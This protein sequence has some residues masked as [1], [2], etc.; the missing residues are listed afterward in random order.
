MIRF[1]I[2]PI[3]WLLVAVFLLQ[4]ATAVE[5]AN[6]NDTLEMEL[7]S[8]I[9]VIKLNHGLKF[10]AHSEF[11]LPT[12]VTDLLTDST[13]NPEGVR[14]EIRHFIT[15][16]NKKKLDPPGAPLTH[17]V[18]R[19]NENDSSSSSG[20]SEEE[21]HN[22][23]NKKEKGNHKKGK[24]DDK[25]SKGDD[26]ESKGDDKESKGDDKKSKGD[27]KK[28]GSISKNHTSSTAD[29]STETAPEQSESFR[30]ARPNGGVSRNGLETIQ[31]ESRNK[32]TVRDV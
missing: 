26:K 11:D 12:N 25:E 31:E 14:I 21:N 24:G 18:R 4:H 32:T 19:S 30:R 17:R 5:V 9:T 16:R 2:L 27:D 1:S 15:L 3:S 28:E 7:D 13:G 6:G 20:S 10:E 23:G 29:S 22:S 8:N